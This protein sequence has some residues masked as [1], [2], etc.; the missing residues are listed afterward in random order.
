MRSQTYVKD[1]SNTHTYSS[2]IITDSSVVGVAGRRESNLAGFGDIRMELHN[3][4][5]AIAHQ[6]SSC[7]DDLWACP[8][9]CQFLLTQQLEPR[10][11]DNV[12]SFVKSDTT[13][14]GLS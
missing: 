1:T 12:T 13:V 7:F 6:P 9:M 2:S 3:I 10:P 11:D 8:G 5:R 4:T 14:A